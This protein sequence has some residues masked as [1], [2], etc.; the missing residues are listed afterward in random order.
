[1]SSMRITRHI[2]ASRQT[3]YNALIDPKAI[4][5]WK[6]PDGMSSFVHE[7]QAC[8][9]GRFRVSLTYE[10]PSESGKTT[11]HTDTYHGYFASL[12]PNERIVEVIEFE[13]TDPAMQGQM[14]I[15]THLR[16]VEGGTE[17]LA[18]HDGLPE[19]VNPTDNEEGWRMSLDKL[20][21]YTQGHARSR[22]PPDFFSGEA[23]LTYDE[24]NSKLAH[25]SDCLHFL[26]GLTLK[27]LPKNSR[28]LCVGVGTGAEILQLARNFPGWSFLALDPSQPMLD[29][30]RERLKNAGVA[31]RCE[32]FHGYIQDLPHQDPFDAVLSV[33]VA[34]FVDREQRPAFFRNMADRLRTGGYLIN[35]EISFD[36]NSQEFP[37]ML[38]NW[39]EI[40]KLMGATEESLQKLPV[41]LRDVLTVIPPAETENLFRMSGIH[42]PVRF[43]QAF[44]I[45]G[46]YGK[47]SGQAGRIT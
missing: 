4:A 19:G 10:T 26:I 12:V 14:T 40:Q 32:F 20:E 9:G 36:L 37:A 18:I 44:M 34:H 22:N 47:K 23:A 28:I 24:R 13:T 2:K 38:N 1:M 39:K 42:C 5:Q 7:F 31:D 27:E 41:I 15:T 45:C 30:C 29:V 21:A 46:W 43:F 11:A 6:V 3:V 33:L 17:L 16:D 25:I 8:E 35:A